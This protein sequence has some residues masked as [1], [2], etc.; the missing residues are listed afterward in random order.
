MAEDW[1]LTVRFEQE[2]GARELAKRLHAPEVEHDLET[3][4]HDR[5]VVSRD[6][7]TVFGYANTRGQAEAAQRVIETLARE[8]GWSVTMDFERWHPVAERWEQPGPELPKTPAEQQEE[9]AE[10]IQSELDES[11][12]QGFPMFEVRV[13]CESH[14]DAQR[15]AQNL[16]AEGIPTA[17][18]W[19]FVVAGAD[20]EDTADALAQR[21]RKE[22]PAGTTVTAEGS[23]QEV[24][25]D[26]PYATQ[27]S[28]FAVFGGL[29]G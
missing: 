1:R 22:A 15:L 4:F 13:K 16:R 21:I 24:T 14:R 3:S 23:M 29:G 26:A 5:V 11:R 9:H 6:G 7:S 18:R 19:E 27:F 20:D 8:H 25:Q 17:Q 10:L 28:P 2:A 12:K